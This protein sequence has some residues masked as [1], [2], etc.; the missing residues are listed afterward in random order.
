MTVTIIRQ[1][2]MALVAVL[3]LVAAMSLII[4][5]VVRAVRTEVQHAGLQ[6]QIVIASATADAAILLALQRIQ[7]QAPG[8][9]SQTR[10]VV[11]DGTTHVVRITPLNGLL[12]INSAPAGLL[13]NLY[14]YAGGTD[15]DVARN[16]AQSTVD[17]RM[18]KNVKG[19]AQG[20]DTVT[21][22]MAVPGMR[23]ELYAKVSPLV[24]ADIKGGSGRVNPLAAPLALLTVL[25]SG[26][27]GRAA[28]YAAQRSANTITADSSF[29]QS[30]H[31]EMTPSESLSLQVDVTLPDG[32]ALRRTW[33]VF[34]GNDVRTGLPWRV[35][36][37][38]PMRT[39]VLTR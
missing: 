24:T 26:D 10:Q 3:W 37:V 31:I 30:D 27:A 22:L 4:G 7:A 16:L 23:Y 18:R 21:D 8:S 13:A 15:P 17:T 38:Q 33:N 36:K 20:F 35:L 2:G 14:R 34:L 9:Q 11:F 25:A 12:D 29:F 32:V 19:Q 5:G 6:R 39:A 1:R 28:Q